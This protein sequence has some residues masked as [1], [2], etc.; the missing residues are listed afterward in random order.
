ML[1]GVNWLKDQGYSVVTFATDSLS[2]LQAINNHSDDTFAI[3]DLLPKVCDQAHLMYV[4]SHKDIA[5][6]EIADKYAKSA[7]TLSGPPDA[8]VP[9]R[10]ALS[11]IKAEIKDAPVT[12]YIL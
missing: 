7:A 1:L 3:R 10:A 8:T 4:P 12:H 5:G 2:L 11:C 6:N 9:L